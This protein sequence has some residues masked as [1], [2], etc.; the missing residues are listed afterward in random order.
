MEPTWGPR[1][2][3]RNELARRAALVELDC[4]VSVWLGIG[5][6]ELI[7][8]LRARYPVLSKYD[9]STFFD[10]GGRKLS[11]YRDNFGPGQTRKDFDALIAHLDDPEVSLPPEGYS[12][13][14]YKADR[15]GEYRQ[16]HAVFSAQL[17]AAA[18]AGWGPSS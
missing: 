11:L 4:L 15:E 8:I 5:I 9:A 3:L 2:P 6:D 10:A 1:T 14:F 17:Q 7:A 13:P 18:D 12:P 16:A